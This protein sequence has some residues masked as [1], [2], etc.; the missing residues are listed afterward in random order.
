MQIYFIR[1]AQSE[2]NHLYDIGGPVDG[3]S[4]DPDLTPKGEKQ[5]EALRKFFSPSVDL[6]INKLDTE[7]DPQ[8]RL[9]FRF[10]HLYAS[11]MI[12]AVKT[13]W[14]VASLFNLPLQLWIDIHE[15][16]GIFLD[17][18]DE[19]PIIL[20]GKNSNYF[21]KTFPGILLDEG[22]TYQGWWN[23]PIETR[24]ERPTRAKRVWDRILSTHM[25]DDSIALFSH[26]GFYNHLLTAVLG[27]YPLETDYVKE[28]FF[29]ELN[30]TGITRI[31]VDFEKEKVRILYNNKVDFLSNDL[32]T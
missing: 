4:E 22:I 17:N 21:T 1:H 16:G 27:L 31:D 10:S 6:P 5:L 13:G 29:F 2:N 3:R 20:P 19:D 18:K 15:T 23:K 14:A 11:P 30:N 28:K 25:P 24:E 9:G 26:G 12:R 7:K 32:I 8:N